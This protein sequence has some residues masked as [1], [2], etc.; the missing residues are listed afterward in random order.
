MIYSEPSITEWGE[1]GNENI[2]ILVMS[3]YF[4]HQ[5]IWNITKMP[6]IANYDLECGGMYKGQNSLLLVKL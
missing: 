4:C 2:S 3:K 5:T 6:K 1:K